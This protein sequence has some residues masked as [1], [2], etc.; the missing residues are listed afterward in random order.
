MEKQVNLVDG[1]ADESAS[2][3][4]FPTSLD[5][6]A[7]VFGRAVP[8][9]VCI[10]L[11]NATQATVPNRPFDKLYAIIEPMLTDDSQL[12]AAIVSKGD[13]PVSRGQVDGHW[14]L[15]QHMLFC[16]GTELDNGKS[17]VR[18][19]ANVNVVYVRILAQILPHGNKFGSVGLRKLLPDGCGPV[20]TGNNFKA[21]IPVRQSVLC[22]N[23]SRSNHADA[24]EVPSPARS[25]YIWP[26]PTETTK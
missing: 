13:H 14:F 11:E 8:L 24:Q 3:L 15:N 26:W 17:E 21:N 19:G 5:R 7:V 25:C 6:A 23:V 12:D 20:G 18:E 22:G 2:A 4:P 9:D 10:G 1:L 16:L